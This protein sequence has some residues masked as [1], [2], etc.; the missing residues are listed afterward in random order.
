MAGGKGQRLRL[1]RIEKPLLEYEGKPLF[2]HVFAALTGSKI[3][4]IVM[5]TS[6][7]TPRTTRV[8]KEANICVVEAPGRGYI[9]DYCWVIMR[10]HIDEPVLIAAADLPLLSSQIIDKVVE[11]Y[12]TSKKPALGVYM[13]QELCDAAGHN[14]EFVLQAHG[15][16]LVPA[17]ISI[18]DGRQIAAAQEEAIL[19]VDDEALLYNINTATDLNK[20]VKDHV[21]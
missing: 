12:V 4:N 5:V 19:V 6:P 1:E 3:H 11:S 2:R 16:P 20:L 8:A 18:V 21:V 15:Q 9:E 14:Y 13:P 10:L 17:A 7:N